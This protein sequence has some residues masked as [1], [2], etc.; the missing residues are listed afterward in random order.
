MT[1]NRKT[2]SP[3]SAKQSTPNTSPTLKPNRALKA[4]WAR[5]LALYNSAVAR[6]SVAFDAKYEAIGRIIDHDPPL[7]LAVG[8][9]SF[10]EFVETYVHEDD[11]VVRKWVEVAKLATPDEEAK[12][13]PSRLALLLGYLRVTSIDGKLPAKFKWESIRVNIAAKG[14]PEKIIRGVD[15]TLTSIA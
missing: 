15:A 2:P 9:K 6:D 4:L 12:W 7:Y 5:E 3:R 10:H 1:A 11:T 13:T 8:C 14:K